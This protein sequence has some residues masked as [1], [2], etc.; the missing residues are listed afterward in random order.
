[1]RS[2]SPYAMQIERSQ[3]HPQHFTVMA[4]NLFYLWLADFHSLI[5]RSVQLILTISKNSYMGMRSLSPNTTQIERCLRR[6]TPTH[7]GSIHNAVR[8]IRQFDS[9]NI[10]TN[11]I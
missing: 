10:T 7:D 9:A 6:A 11:K 8:F 4:S 3:L 5:L 2:P 1:M